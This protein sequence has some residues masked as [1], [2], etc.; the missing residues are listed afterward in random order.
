M[1]LSQ[2]SGWAPAAIYSKQ[3][4]SLVLWRTELDSLPQMQLHQCV[5]E[6]TRPPD[7]AN[8]LQSTDSLHCLPASVLSSHIQPVYWLREIIRPRSSFCCQTAKLL[9]SYPQH[10]QSGKLHQSLNRFNL[11]MIQSAT[12]LHFLETMHTHGKKK[13]RKRF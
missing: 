3:E 12:S 11:S 2:T 10:F 1:S 7:L 9:S 5:A 8:V 4:S 13:K 6:V